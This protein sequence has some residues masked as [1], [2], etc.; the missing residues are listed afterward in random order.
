[1]ITKPTSK[2]K[3]HLKRVDARTPLAIELLS[4]DIKEGKLKNWEE[5]A[6]AVA[7]KRQEDVVAAYFFRSCAY[8]EYEDKLV[9][10]HLPP[11]VQKEIVSFD[12][13]GTIEPGTYCLSPVPPRSRRE[14]QNKRARSKGKR[15][16]KKGVT[17]K[18]IHHTQAIRNAGQVLLA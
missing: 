14:V 11:S 17:R 7:C 5:C 9:R 1:M 16:Y 15:K 3:R 10:Y 18:V 13:G 4:K 6:F 8:L 12:R 2:E